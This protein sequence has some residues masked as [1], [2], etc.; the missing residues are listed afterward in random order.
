MSWIQCFI[1]HL[2]PNPDFLAQKFL[3]FD[4]LTVKIQNR[5]ISH[6]CSFYSCAHQIVP[7]SEPCNV[8]KESLGLD[9]GGQLVRRQL[10]ESNFIFLCARFILFHKLS[11][12]SEITVDP[13]LPLC[14]ILSRNFLRGRYS[15]RHQALK[16]ANWLLPRSRGL[17]LFCWI[18]IDQGRSCYGKFN[19]SVSSESSECECMFPRSSVSIRS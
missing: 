8:H 6:I 9:R 1:P 7:R 4:Y 18:I 10:S 19:R 16:I 14:F 15:F 17:R 5:I 12:V 3:Y 11:F 2:I 13:I